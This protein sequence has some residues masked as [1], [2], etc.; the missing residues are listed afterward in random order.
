MRIRSLSLSLLIVLLSTFV[1][2]QRSARP[3]N[4]PS[5]NQ[6]KLA[7]DEYEL[8][9]KEYPDS[10]RTAQVRQSMAQLQAKVQ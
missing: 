9:L 1:F 2:A 8:Y 3:A 4:M 6:P 5:E 10:P 7:I